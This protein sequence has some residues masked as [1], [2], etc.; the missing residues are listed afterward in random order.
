MTYPSRPIAAQAVPDSIRE[1][2]RDFYRELPRGPQAPRFS[3]VRALREMH[4]PDGLRDGF[5][6]EVLGSFA[7]ALGRH[8][9]PHRVTIPW[10]VL[11]PYRDLAAAPAA[12]D[13]ERGTGHERHQRDL[14]AASG[15]SAGYLIGEEQARVVDVLR[16]WSIVV[17]GG[18]QV[19][20]MDSGN[21]VVPRN[22]GNST[23][24]W[25]ATEGT[26]TTE[27]QPTV[28]D[29]MLSPKT[30]AVYT[31]FSHVLSKVAPQLEFFLRQHLLGSVGQAVDTAVF[32]GTGA[33]GQ[34]LG[35]L[36]T[37]GVGVVSG[38]SIDWAGVRTIRK[39]AIGAGAREEN[40]IFV[41]GSTAQ[42]VLAGRERISGGSHA[43]WDDSGNMAGLR[44]V[45]TNRIP[46][47][48][49]VCGDFSQ[50]VMALWGGVEV[51]INPFA[52][53]QAGIQG[54]RVMVAMDAG[55]LNP[56][57]FSVVTSIT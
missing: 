33:S 57:A 14:T 50:V 41:G 38:S 8:Y 19:I 56:G 27:V 3:L 31:E 2:L 23:G 16:G 52:N 39:S 55:V 11:S 36:N 29:L 18:I 21:L 35:I 20:P 46:L 51:E 49:V 34:P 28:G 30:C 45:A 9:D 54:A 53:F 26:N 37:P 12:D 48:A 15:P 43:I 1:A 47:D 22:I 6:R 17:D 25:L 7:V 4:T 40:M 10:A 44:A 5:E 32:G 13:W 42:D 24:Y